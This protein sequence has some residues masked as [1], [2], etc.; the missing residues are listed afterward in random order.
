MSAARELLL[1]RHAKSSWDDATLSDHERALNARGLRDAPRIGAWLQAQGL[2][3][4]QLLSSDARRARQTLALVAAELRPGPLSLEMDPRIYEASLDAL[5]AVLAGCRGERVL[6]VGH[7]P[8]MEALAAHLL[9]EPPAA[10][11]TLPTAALVHIALPPD[12][13]ALDRACGRLLALQSPKTL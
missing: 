9:S 13:T 5:L 10:V 8:G 6:L 12:W 1:L 4:D 11:R 7:N 2:L 3:P